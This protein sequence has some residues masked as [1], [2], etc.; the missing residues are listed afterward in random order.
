MREGHPSER[1]RRGA[2][3]SLFHSLLV[4]SL[5]LSP[6][7]MMKEVLSYHTGCSFTSLEGLIKK[8]P[9]CSIGNSKTPL[10]W[11]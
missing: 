4:L 8:G 1:V 9:V 6:S 7:T 2:D 3:S 11:R 5:I 10:S